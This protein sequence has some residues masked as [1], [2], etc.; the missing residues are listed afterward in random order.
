MCTD[1]AVMQAYDTDSLVIFVKFKHDLQAFSPLTKI[2]K[3]HVNMHTGLE[4]TQV[5][6]IRKIPKTTSG[7]VQRF[8]L[9]EDYQQGIFEDTITELNNVAQTT[10][11]TSTTNN[12]EQQ[13]LTICHSIID[14]KPTIALVHRVGMPQ[15]GGFVYMERHFYL[16][17][18]HNC[19]QGIGAA[20]PFDDGAVVLLC[21]PHEYR[22]G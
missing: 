6:P 1:R 15:D 14:D 12:I 16:S 21:Y 18:S 4:V 10:P 17:R 22:S 9:A 5:L 3:Q 11:N 2:I 8:A 7:K 13:L 20:L 19:L